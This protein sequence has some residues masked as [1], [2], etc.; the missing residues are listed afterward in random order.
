MEAAQ[1]TFAEMEEMGVCQKASSRWSSPLHIILKRDGSLCLCRDGILGNPPFCVYYMDNKLV[2]LTSKEE[3][4]S[5]LCIVLDRQ[6]PLTT[7]LATLYA[8]LKGKPKD[9]K[10]G[11][12]QEVAFCNAKNTLSI[13][14]ALTFPGVLAPLLFST[15]SS[16]ISI[17]A[18]L[19]QVG[20]V[21]PCPLAFFNRKLS[22][23]EYIYSTLD[24]ELL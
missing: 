3:H 23:A 13:A 7:K 15:N 20:N 16:D 18:A 5:H 10:W 17:S 11:P 1:Q 21:L 12:L 14:A 4:L 19:E 24:P 6:Q 2:F 22:K 9:L 8:S